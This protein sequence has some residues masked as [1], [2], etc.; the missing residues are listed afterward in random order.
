MSVIFKTRNASMTNAD[1]THA[2]ARIA[3]LDVTYHTQMQETYPLS[4]TKS[5]LLPLR[6]MKIE[7]TMHICVCLRFSFLLREDV[8]YMNLYPSSV[9]Q[10]TV[11]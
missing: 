11:D 4:N 1:A 10:H 8:C 5:N 9:C 6:W 3:I 2:Q 7:E